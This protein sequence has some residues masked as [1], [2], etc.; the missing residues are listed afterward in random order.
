MTAVYGEMQNKVETKH[1]LA[2]KTAHQ[3]C[4]IIAESQCVIA[5]TLQMP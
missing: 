2:E 3:V 4:H 1:Q 5:K